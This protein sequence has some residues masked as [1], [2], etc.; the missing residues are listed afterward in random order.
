MF[1]FDPGNEDMSGRILGS[2]AVGAAQTTADANVKLVDDI[3]SAL[4]GLAGAYGEMEGNKAKGRAFKDVF[5]VAAPSMGMS[6]EQLESISGGK[7]K[8]DMDWYNARES[9]LPLMPSLINAQ[10]GQNRLGVQQDQQALTARM[11][12]LRNAATAQAQVAS[13]RGRM[14]TMPANINPDVIP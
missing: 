10:L 11:P 4:V 12:G 3:G 6:M 2:A 9:F 5:K 7:L 13:G 14:T 1:A 8:N